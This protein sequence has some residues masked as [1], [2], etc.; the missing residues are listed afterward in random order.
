MLNS[1]AFYLL[2]NQQV[3]AWNCLVGLCCMIRPTAILIWIPSYLSL[4]LTRRL[5]FL[6]ETFII[7]YF[8]L[9]V[10]CITVQVLIDSWYFGK[11]TVTFWNFLFFNFLS[12]GSEFYGRQPWHWMVTDGLLVVF[13]S[14]FPVLLWALVKGVKN[15]TWVSY[16]F[17]LLAISLSV[18]KEYRFL[19]SS[20]PQGIYLMSEITGCISRSHYFLAVVQI[21]IALFL[22][23][24]HQVAP[25]AVMDFLQTSQAS[26]VGFFINCHG[27]PFYSH[28][29]RD[30]PMRF[31]QCRPFETQETLEFYKNPE[32]V[33]T[34]HLASMNY[35][36]IV[37]WSTMYPK[38]ESVLSSYNVTQKFFHAFWTE[39]FE[40]YE[41]NVYF[42]LLSKISS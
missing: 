1:I 2:Q 3:F 10:F 13:A 9:R 12:D 11:V 38:V 22:S 8:L 24:F 27:T 23:L 40:G 28:L 29:H 36:H 34:S 25:L 26:S 30:I 42:Y 5:K 14:Y 15:L 32:K 37:I 7:A 16:V 33:L 31:L 18:H 20:F 19:L 35:S 39:S 41:S 21:G 4:S 6:K 17:F